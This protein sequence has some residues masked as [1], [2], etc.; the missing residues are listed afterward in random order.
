[1]SD[2]EIRFERLKRDTA[3]IVDEQM[4]MKDLREYM[5]RLSTK[6]NFMCCQGTEH[7]R[8]DSLY[9]CADVSITV[10]RCCDTKQVF[11]LRIAKTCILHMVFIL[12]TEISPTDF[13][14]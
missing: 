13:L 14:P 1:M 7:S 10:L 8:D 4:F 6:N 9:I 3:G 2:I 5:P 11:L 12:E